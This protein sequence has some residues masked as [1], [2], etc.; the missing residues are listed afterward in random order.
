[1]EVCATGIKAFRMK[2]IV[3]SHQVKGFVRKGVHTNSDHL[4]GQMIADENLRPYRLILKS[5][6]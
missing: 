4:L 2:D 6:S 1:M 5:N 3:T